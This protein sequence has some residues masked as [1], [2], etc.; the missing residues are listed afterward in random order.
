MNTG[1]AAHHVF[2]T[3][4]SGVGKTAV[5]SGLRNRGITCIDMDEPGWSYMDA[6][7]YQHWNVKRLGK[8]MEK[9]VDEELF[10]S[11]CAEEQAGLYHK[12]R[13]IILLSAPRE[14]V[15]DRIRSRTEN[16]FGQNPAEME[17]ILSDLENI[18]PHLREK[19][20]YEISTTM[21]VKDVV[22][23][24]LELAYPINGCRQQSQNDTNLIN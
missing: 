19:C 4:M 23:R 3:G 2:I 18:G 10:V 8:A 13:I 9:T 15:L 7:G 21:P 17:H 22:D 20:T 12:F 11:G 6:D 5:I 16:S 1:S 24:I 14:I